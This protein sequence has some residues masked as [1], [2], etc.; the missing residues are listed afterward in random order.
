VQI[1]YCPSQQNYLWEDAMA[2]AKKKV[3]KKKPVA[4]K[5]K[6]AKKAGCKKTTRKR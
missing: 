1:R 4:K 5:K 3:V 6:P 2:I